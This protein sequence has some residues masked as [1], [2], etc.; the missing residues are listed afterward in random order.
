MQTINSM[1]LNILEVLYTVLPIS[2]LTHACDSC[3]S[4]RKMLYDTRKI[5]SITPQVY[6]TY[7][8]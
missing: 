8:L 3:A 7:Y 6:L 1:W 5:F 4:T 2:N